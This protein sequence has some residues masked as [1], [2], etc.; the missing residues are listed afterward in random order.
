LP[1]RESNRSHHNR[2]E[3]RRN[4]LRLS[5]RR[6]R[7]GSRLVEW[8][9]E[10]RNLI[11]T[12]LGYLH[13]GGGRALARPDPALPPPTPLGRHT[14]GAGGRSFWNRTNRQGG[15]SG[16]RALGQMLGRQCWRLLTD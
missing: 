4:K 16:G 12:A 15:E 10:R 9:P 2:S 13:D 1:A 5:S 3:H 8:E 7:S 14:R 11:S 6:Q